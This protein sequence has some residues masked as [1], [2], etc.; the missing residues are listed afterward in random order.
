[1]KWSPILF[2]EARSPR[3]RSRDIDPGTGAAP[4]AFEPVPV[5]LETKNVPISTPSARLLHQRE[6]GRHSDHVT[7]HALAREREILWIDIREHEAR[8]LRAAFAQQARALQ[9]IR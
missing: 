5:C 8:E 2:F 4:R 7:I 9:E 6:P 1:M 3:E